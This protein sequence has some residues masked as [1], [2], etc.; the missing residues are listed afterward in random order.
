LGEGLIGAGEANA[1]IKG[2][3][4]CET[5]WEQNE[6]YVD[7]ISDEDAAEFYSF[8]L[9]QLPSEVTL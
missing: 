4:A 6:R 1:V 2:G 7:V 8:Q 5:L 9:L 3:T